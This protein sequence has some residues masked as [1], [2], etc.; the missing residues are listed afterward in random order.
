M[1]IIVEHRHEKHE[2]SDRQHVLSLLLEVVHGRL[3]CTDCVASAAAYLLAMM[4]RRLDWTKDTLLKF[5]EEVWDN[6]GK[7]YEER[8]IV[9]A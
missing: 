7:Q 9:A 8:G 5:I 3:L 1:Q 6:L 4:G 2:L